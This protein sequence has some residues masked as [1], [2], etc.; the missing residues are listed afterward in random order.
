MVFDRKAAPTSSIRS[1]EGNVISLL[2][3][4]EVGNLRLGFRGGEAS[5]STCRY[6][7][8]RRSRTHCLFSS[9]APDRSSRRPRSCP[10]QGERGLGEGQGAPGDA[11]DSRCRKS[12]WDRG[13]RP[14][15]RR[16]ACSPCPRI[17]FH[18]RLRAGD[19]LLG[20]DQA[21]RTP[22]RLPEVPNGQ[23]AGHEEEEEVFLGLF[24]T[25]ARSVRSP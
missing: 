6:A 22:Q 7:P 17:G 20:V 11:Q 10:L 15:C 14:P 12:R 1:L 4:L 8:A 2:Q 9:S 3:L 23:V 19:R 13:T 24:L 18:D 21:P 5:P 16:G 25:P